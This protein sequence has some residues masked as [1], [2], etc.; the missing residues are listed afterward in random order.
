MKTSFCSPRTV[1][2][3]LAL[4][5]FG[6]GLT[7]VPATAQIRKMS[8]REIRAETKRAN[9]QAKRMVR[10]AQQDNPGT[11]AFLDMSVY[12][13]RPNQQGRKSVKAADG[14]DNY[15]FTRSGDPIVTD[16]PTLTNKRLK[17]KK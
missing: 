14:R 17:R 12:D 11:E 16:A 8:K 13:M 15:Q 5:L 3:S 2:L 6:A 7:P 10:Q 9:R 4:L 1:G